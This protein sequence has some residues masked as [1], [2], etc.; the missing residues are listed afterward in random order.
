MNNLDQQTEETIQN[1]EHYE[2]KWHV[3]K[4]ILFTILTAF[5]LLFVGYQGNRIVTTTNNNTERTQR[6]I[7]CIILLPA[8][9]FN[10][11]TEQRTKAIDTCSLQTQI[12]NRVSK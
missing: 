8:R 4:I 7:R 6:Y 10:V 9:S 3:F 11:T 5:T 1:L 12:P 2:R